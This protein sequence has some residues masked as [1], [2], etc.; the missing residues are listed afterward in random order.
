MNESEGLNERLLLT[1]QN[2]GGINASQPRTCVSMAIEKKNLSTG[3]AKYRPRNRDGLNQSYAN[4]LRGSDA[5][6]Q[7]STKPKSSAS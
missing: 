4:D 6:D 1:E 3:P 7:L 2:D 5:I